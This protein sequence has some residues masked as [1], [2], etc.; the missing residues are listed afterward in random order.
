MVSGWTIQ[1]VSF[2]S[3]SVGKVQYSLSAARYVYYVAECENGHVKHVAVCGD[4]PPEKMF[5]TDC[6]KMLWVNWDATADRFP[7]TPRW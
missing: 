2:F 5:C 1:N 7:L 4:E 6:R 3:P